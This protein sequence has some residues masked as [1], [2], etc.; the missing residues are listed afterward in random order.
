M[1]ASREDIM[2]EMQQLGTITPSFTDGTIATASRPD[3]SASAARAAEVLDAP[4]TFQAMPRSTRTAPA[5]PATLQATTL[6][7]D[8]AWEAVLARDARLD[9]RL[10]YA[11]ATTGVY[12][13]PS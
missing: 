1:R 9:G 7:D 6:A 13:K 2:R 11:V 10:Y 5:G 4:T 8:D 12:C 3:W